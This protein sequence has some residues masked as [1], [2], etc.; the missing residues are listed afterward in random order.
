MKKILIVLV[1]LLVSGSLMFSSKPTKADGTYEAVIDNNGATVK[2]RNSNEAIMKASSY[3][4]PTQNLRAC[5]VSLFVGSMPR[6]TNEETWKRNYN[7]VLD[8]METYGLN[9]IIFHVRTHNN[10][11]YKSKLNPVATWFENVNFDEFDPLAWAIEETHKRGFEFHAWLNPYRVSDSFCAESYPA[12]NPA[13]NK[14]NLLTAGSTILN[15]GLP[16]VRQFLV[17]TCMEVVENYDVDAIHFDDYFYIKGVDD[18]ATRNMYNPNN[19]SV[20]DWRREQVNMFISSLSTSIRKYNEQ[21]NKCVQLGIAPS[22]IYRNGNYVQTPTYDANGNLTSPL[23]SDTVGMEHYGGYLYADTLKWINEEWIDYIMPQLYW[24]LEHTAASFGALTRW[25][26]WAVKNKKV[27]LY[28]G[29]GIYMAEST[30]GSGAYWQKNNN[31]IRDQI[32][33]ASMYEEIGGISLYSYNYINSSNSIIKRGMDLLKNDYF[34]VKIPCDVKKSYAG[35]LAKPL[36]KNINTTDNLLSWQECNNVRGYMIYKVIKGGKVNQNDINQIYYYGTSNSKELEDLENYDYYISTINYANEASDPILAYT[37]EANSSYVINLIKGLSDAI[38][39]DDKEKL[40]AIETCYQN[41]TETAKLEVTNYQVLENA[42]L[43]YNEKLS[44]YNDILS[45]I[46]ISKYSDNYQETIKKNQLEFREKINKAKNDETFSIYFDEYKVL[47]DFYPTLE[48]ELTSTK[49]NAR[50]EI[51]AYYD[52]LDKEYY[53]DENLKNLEEIY[54]KCLE[55][56]DNTK[57]LEDI[58]NIVEKAKDDMSSILDFKDTYVELLEKS[59]KELTTY[60]NGLISND[61]YDNDEKSRI[62]NLLNECI[63][64]IELEKKSDLVT[65]YQTIVNKY[66]DNIDSLDKTIKE[67]KLENARKDAVKLINDAKNKK[68]LETLQNEYLS[69][70]NSATSVDEINELIAEFNQK[71]EKLDPIA[72]KK[73]SKKATIFIEFLCGLSLLTIIIR[74]KDN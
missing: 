22:G 69:K 12:S 70:V 36:V 46:D 45:Y 18:T 31:E 62:T 4:Y 74:K 32:L 59:K 23:A 54:Q 7:Q 35:K 10:A 41:L 38:S 61:N 27:N 66:K 3:N 1:M 63:K 43:V 30:T 64:N 34:S 53:T 26:S 8:N 6:Y 21:N 60:T 49:E 13:S 20:A 17:D 42:F 28:C 33:N 52:S 9:C 47:I 14:E 37:S 44:I 68:D 65:S 73:C 51:K 25:W 58:T 16:I 29:M 71:Y 19:L 57:I 24:A 40:D 2:Y 5:W 72:T 15:P 39:L 11:L 50:K 56:I 55:D 48:E 67:E